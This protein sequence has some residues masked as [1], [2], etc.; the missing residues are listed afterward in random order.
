VAAFEGFDARWATWKMAMGDGSRVEDAGGRIARGRYGE[1]D[2]TGWTVRLC[3]KR[4]RRRRE[5][6]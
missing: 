5:R 1:L 3:E 2:W 6:V 4:R